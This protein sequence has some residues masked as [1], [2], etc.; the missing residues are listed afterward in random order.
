[1]LVKNLRSEMAEKEENIRSFV[2]RCLISFFSVYLSAP[3]ALHPNPS[4]KE[5][6]GGVVCLAET[7][8]YKSNH[9]T[10]PVIILLD[11]NINASFRDPVFPGG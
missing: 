9:P 4:P 7:H 6:W 8:H 5:G 11:H 10:L 3:G 2:L 1:M